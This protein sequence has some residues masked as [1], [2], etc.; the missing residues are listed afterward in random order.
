[1]TSAADGHATESSYT[2]AEAA[3]LHERALDIIAADPARAERGHLNSNCAVPDPK[4]GK[5]VNVRMPTPIGERNPHVW[6]IYHEQDIHT[7]VE[8]AGLGTVTAKYLYAHPQGLFSLQERSGADPLPGPGEPFASHLPREFALF[9]R[10]LDD[11]ELPGGLDADTPLAPD[12]IAHLRTHS[13]SYSGQRNAPRTSAEYADLMSCELE[14]NENAI[15]IQ[16]EYVARRLG[17]PGNVAE[18]ARAQ[19]QGMPDAPLLPTHPDMHNGNLGVRN[20]HLFFYDLEFIGYHD[21]RHAIAYALWNSKTT[22]FHQAAKAEVIR[23][24]PRGERADFAEGVRCWE[25]FATLHSATSRLK[26][27]QDAVLSAAN[28]GRN[29]ESTID[30]YG[31]WLAERVNAAAPLWDSGRT[32]DADEA[33]AALADTVRVHQDRRILRDTGL[34]VDTAAR[35]LGTLT[36]RPTVPGLGNTS[37][38]PLKSAAQERHQALVPSLR[39]HRSP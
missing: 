20:G 7:A 26:R 23:S 38:P 17:F 32:L 8:A 6:R 39:L 37:A 11:V 2:D 4:S 31:R 12:A 30:K 34:P 18:H 35:G 33:R 10:R 5:D 14:A 19:L 25:R 24:M 9:F 21:R 3:S 27:T 1:M 22:E 13:P 36:A 29:L 28:S 15:M 16:D